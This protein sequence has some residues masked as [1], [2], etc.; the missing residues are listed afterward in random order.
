MNIEKLSIT[1]VHELTSVEIRS[2]LDSIPDLVEAIEVDADSRLKRWIS[3]FT[4]ESPSSSKP[5]RIVF[6]VT[7]AGEIIGYI[8]GH[9][10]SRFDVDLEIQ[11]FYILKKWQR[12]SIGTNLLVR[13]SQWAQVKGYVSACVGVAPLNPYRS[14]Y[15][16]HGAYVRNQHWLEWGNLPRSLNGA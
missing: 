8:A 1:D 3:Y 7:E 13:L 14:F 15:L 11:S 4:G 9:H 12:K 5:D 10:T 6:G 2:K 16:K